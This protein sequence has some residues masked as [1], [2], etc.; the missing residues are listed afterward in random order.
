MRQLVG[1][2]FLIQMVASVKAQHTFSIVA[3][4]SIT[5]EIGSAGATCGDSIIWPGTKGALVISDVMPGL[6][7]IHTQSYWNEQNQA[8]ARKRLENGDSPDDIIE[9]LQKN[10][11]EDNNS[12]RQYGMVAWHNGQVKAAGFTGDNCLDYKDHIVGSHY[13]IQGNILK[14]PEILDSME[15]RFLRSKGP[16]ASR[17]MSAMQGANVVGADSRCT[18]EGT[19]SLSAFL[20]VAKKDDDASKLF[21][22]INVAGTGE[23]V[24]PID[25]LQDRFN[26]WRIKNDMDETSVRWFSTYPNPTS[27]MVQIES[28]IPIKSITVIN[29]TGKQ[30]I[31]DKATDGHAVIDM[32]EQPSGIYL[33]VVEPVNPNYV[34][35][36]VRLNVIH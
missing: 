20:R 3:I 5:G 30:K 33:L 23:G 36:T 22:D 21:L 26:K 27:H 12:I 9:W 6:G 25:I 17:L 2:V 15:A 8:N 13:A 28:R 34:F 31:V 11:I 10:D 35:R 4:D 7:T 29:A 24:E 1:I 32:S 16:L 18:S 19:S 14:G